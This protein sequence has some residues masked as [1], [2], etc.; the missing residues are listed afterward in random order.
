M[1]FLGFYIGDQSVEKDI[2]GQKQSNRVLDVKF[3]Y[4]YKLFF[5]QA[6]NLKKIKKIKATIKNVTGK[7]LQMDIL[8]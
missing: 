7:I 3:S 5:L 8:W 2:V 4:I 1:I 6:M